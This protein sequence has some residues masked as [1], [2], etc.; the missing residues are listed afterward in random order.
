MQNNDISDTLSN[1]VL[2]RIEIFLKAGCLWMSFS[3]P[4]M[5]K[6]YCAFVLLKWM[7]L[8]QLNV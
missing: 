8:Y 5:L 3:I 1:D 6:F 2:C 7:Y 4:T